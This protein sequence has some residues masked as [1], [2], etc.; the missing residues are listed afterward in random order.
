M[1]PTIARH[2]GQVQLEHSDMRLALNMV[3]MAKGRVSHALIDETQQQF[4]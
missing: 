2:R 3:E 1:S 4:R